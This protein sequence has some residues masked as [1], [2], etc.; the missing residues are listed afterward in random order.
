MH[1]TTDLSKT[2]I[3]KLFAM[4]DVDQSGLIDFNEFYI[5]ICILLAVR[6]SKLLCSYVGPSDCLEEFLQCPLL[7]GQ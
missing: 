5:L 2:K 3:C 6:V 7:L 1:I 4:L